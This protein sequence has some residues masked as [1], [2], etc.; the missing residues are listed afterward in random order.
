MQKNNR[1]VTSNLFSKPWFHNH[2][3]NIIGL[4][5]HFHLWFCQAI[6]YLTCKVKKPDAAKHKIA[7]SKH[8]IIISQN[9][10]AQSSCRCQG[11]AAFLTLSLSSKKPDCN[12]L[13]ISI[14]IIRL[15]ET[16]ALYHSWQG[17]PAMPASP[18]GGSQTR[19]YKLNRICV[20]LICSWQFINWTR[21]YAEN[22]D[23]KRQ[24]LKK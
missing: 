1:F 21:I 13:F 14:S 20:N 24:A 8:T 22:V 10:T 15:S 5:F 18:T 23:K 4:V 7:E 19:P 17:S 12:W 9:L 3:T 11:R 16:G 2:Q 6:F